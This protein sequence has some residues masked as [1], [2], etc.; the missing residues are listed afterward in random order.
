MDCS[1]PGSF[2]HGIFQMR[3]LDWVAIS[4]SRGFP[5]PGINPKSLVSPAF[6]IDSLPL[7]PPGKNYILFYHVVT[8]L[9][10]DI[11]EYKV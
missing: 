10:P 8:H 9:E 6:T 11:L 3:I 2:V 7:A 4:S 5:H 1:L